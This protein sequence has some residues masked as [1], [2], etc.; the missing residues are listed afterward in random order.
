MKQLFPL[1][2]LLTITCICGCQRT[3]TVAGQKPVAAK[4]ETLFWDEVDF[5]DSLHCHNK[6]WL[7]QQFAQFLTGKRHGNIRLEYRK[8]A[9]KFAGDTLVLH[10]I[11]EIAEHYLADPNS[12]ARNE[13]QYCIFL[14]EILGNKMLPEAERL[15]PTEQLRL[16]RMNRPGSQAT[17]FHYTT[18]EGH[19][20]NLLTVPTGKWLLLVF[21]DPACSHCEA[22]LESLYQ[23]EA[24][25]K[26]TAA[27][28]MKVLAIYTE[29]NRKL[30]NKTKAQMPPDWTVGIDESKIVERE[31]YN[32]PAMPTLYLL[33]QQKTVLLK[34][35]TPEALE[36]FILTEN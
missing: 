18:R 28:K 13:E 36:A 10:H 32:L 7:E 23:S 34:D 30:W 22:I 14:E 12:P 15:R 35:P 24:I 6:L 4:Q 17:D 5:T 3:K 8:L 25:S 27:D 31:L 1:L 33:D 20:G 9:D 16:A 21:Y 19:K 2:L 11:M 26:L 29:G